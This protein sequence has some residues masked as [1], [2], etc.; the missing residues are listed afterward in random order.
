MG[1]MYEDWNKLFCDELCEEI[2]KFQHGAR[3]DEQLCRIEKLIKVKNGLAEM[4]MDGAIRRIAEDRY[5][6]DS[7]TGSFRDTDQMYEFAEM[8]NASRGGRGGRGRRRDSRGRYMNAVRPTTYYPYDPDMYPWDVPYMMND[9]RDY[10]A[11]RPAHYDDEQIMNAGRN[12]N[13]RG[14]NRSGSGSRRTVNNGS[15]YPNGSNMDDDG[16]YMLRQQNGMPIMT[17]YNM[18]H[19][20]PKKLT[21]QQCEE[22]MEMLVGPSGEEG[23]HWTKPQIEAEAKRSGIDVSKYGLPLITALSN[24]MWADYSSVAK[25][26]NVDK[27]SFYI[28]L[29]D[30]FLNDA[31]FNGTP[32]EK[33]SIYFHKIAE[34]E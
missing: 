23:P 13:G 25:M 11:D 1:K 31:D 6:Y 2:K 33:A 10:S 26:Y 18:G 29:A 12:G 34:H 28:R 15:S 19:D 7:D 16:M 32:Q 17:P 22:W 30:A 5:G 4:E 20:V 9:G 3:N 14:G 27:P 21:E 8:F 24:A